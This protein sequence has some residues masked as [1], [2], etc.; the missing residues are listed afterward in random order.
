MCFWESRRTMKDGMFTTCFRTLEGGWQVRG[1]GKGSQ[2][3]ET[4]LSASTLQ[5]AE[6]VL[7]PH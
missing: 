1:G 3:D 4:L 2:Q 7:Q 6:W 5:P